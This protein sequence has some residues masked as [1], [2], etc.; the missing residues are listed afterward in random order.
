MK[1]LSTQATRVLS[2]RPIAKTQRLSAAVAAAVAKAAALLQKLAKMLRPQ[3]LWKTSQAQC[4][5]SQEKSLNFNHIQ[6]TN[7][8]ANQPTNQS[9]N[10]PTN[11]PTTTSQPTNQSTK[12]STRRWL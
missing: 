1:K 3:R 4:Q 12:P 2:R 7:Q 9:I 11:Q 6:P 5:T 8:P 10:Q